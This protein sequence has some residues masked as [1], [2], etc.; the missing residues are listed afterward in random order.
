M[1][2]VLVPL[3]QSMVIEPQVSIREVDERYSV[4]NIIGIE[5]YQQRPISTM[6]WIAKC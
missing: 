6:H 4:M 1:S 2:P 5:A 3:G